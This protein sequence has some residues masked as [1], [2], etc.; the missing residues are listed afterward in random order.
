MP[1]SLTAAAPS[2][3]CRA[4][5]AHQKPISCLPEQRTACKTTCNDS[6]LLSSFLCPAARM[7]PPLQALLRLH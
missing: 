7:L 3:C 4:S 2:G 5:A 1:R 6:V